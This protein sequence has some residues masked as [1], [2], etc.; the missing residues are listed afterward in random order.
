MNKKDCWFDVSFWNEEETTTKLNKALEICYEVHVWT[1]EA[2]NNYWRE[3]LKMP[4]FSNFRLIAAKHLKGSEW[5]KY[6]QRYTLDRVVEQTFHYVA[7]QM[8]VQKK[9]S[10]AIPAKPMPFEE[11]NTF[12]IEARKIWRKYLAEDRGI[13][14]TYGIIFP[15]GEWKKIVR[16]Q[17]GKVDPMLIP[18]LWHSVTILKS[19]NNWKMRFNFHEPNSHKGKEAKKELRQDAEDLLSD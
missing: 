15:E 14:T 8:R 2:A 6:V 18:Y 16:D 7:I 13:S 4:R 12:Q 10:A 9:K 1:V 19:G 11:F 17:V 5:V 3:H